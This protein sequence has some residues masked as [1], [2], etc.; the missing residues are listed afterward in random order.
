[1]WGLQPTVW[2]E[3]RS[4]AGNPSVGAFYLAHWMA[5]RLYADFAYWNVRGY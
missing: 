2:I 1:M 5:P 4:A 3:W